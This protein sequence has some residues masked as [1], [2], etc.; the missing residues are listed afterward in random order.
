MCLMLIFDFK[1]ENM[2]SFGNF[3]YIVCYYISC[4]FFIIL[5]CY[6]WY[7]NMCCSGSI[8]VI[9]GCDNLFCVCFYEIL[10]FIF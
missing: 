10:V 4:F 6:E 3:S 1:L 8:V 5:K 7:E 2:M 9:I